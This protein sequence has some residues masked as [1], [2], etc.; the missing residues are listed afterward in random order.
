MNTT[1]TAPRKNR[2]SL[3]VSYSLLT[4]TGF[5]SSQSAFSQA[6]AASGSTLDEIIVTA[7]RRS[8][9]LQDVPVAVQALGEKQLKDLRVANLQ[10][11]VS[12][13]PGVN[14]T[15]Q[16]PGRKEV[17]I[18]GISP[19]RTAERIAALGSEASVASY[20]DETPTSYA[21]RD[22]DLYAADFNR[23][24]VLKGPQGTLFGASSQG[25]AIRLITNKPDPEEFAA[26]IAVDFADTSGGEASN[27]FEG[28]INIP[29][30]AD[31][32]ALRIVAYQDDRGGY[33]DNIAATR[34][35]PLTNPGLQ[36]AATAGVVGF[37]ET[38]NNAAL[39]EDDVNDAEYQG[40]RASLK[41]FI[42]D[43]WS[44]TATVISQT[45]DT[46]GIFEF[47]PDVS[48]DDDLNAR[49][50]N[51][52]VGED[53][54]DLIS[55]N[56]EGSVGDLD[57]IYSGSYTER[58]FEG[59]TDY[60]GYANTGPFIP[61][62]IC[63]PGYTSCGSPSLITDSFFETERTTHE[64]RIASNYDSPFNFIAGIFLDDQE[65]IERTNFIY[66]ASVGVGFQPNFPIPTAFAS[67]PNAR[68]PGVTFFN[69]FLQTTEELS[70]FGEVSY[71]FNDRFKLTLGARRYDIDI[72]LTGQSSFG[73]RGSGPEAA[74]GVNVDA[75]LAG[76]T[77]ASLSDTIFRFN[78]SYDV[79]DNGLLYFT[80]SEGFRSGRF[81]RNGGGGNGPTPIPFFFESDNAK[82]YE[83]GYKA[84]LL[85]NSLRFSAAAYFVDFTDLQQGVL[86]FSIDNV[87]FFD[88]VG[89]A[90]IRGFEFETDWAPTDNLRLFSSFSYID[91]ELVELPETVANIAPEGSELPF[92]PK[93]QSTLGARYEQEFGNLTGF[94]QGVATYTDE[95]FTSLVQAAR[96]QLD[97]Y[98]QVNTSIGVS[99]DNWTAS[100]YVDNLTDELGT[101]DG[102][103]PD[104]IFRLIPIRPRT[105]G[106]RFNYNF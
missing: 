48:G 46:E 86:D 74:G 102:G 30:V 84:T 38:A 14:A 23:I 65:T 49:V 40:Y 22:I 5:S 21:G 45:L 28:F 15:G 64:I 7:T 34:Q 17:F 85:D 36:A 2:L 97:S 105:I 11:Y 52:N 79:N 94:A 56:I 89:D 98:T 31:T 42:N 91:S 10:D 106:V 76:Q 47:E 81:N 51:Q 19:G 77:P 104:L 50:F 99:T 62:Y 75:N 33:I 87:S 88:N 63:T 4:L 18:R 53:E 24:E 26:G 32:T 100:L 70:L 41:H 57:L 90:E 95:R 1:F 12:L 3:A 69:D 73:S 78:A 101:L 82:N 83:L 103:A 25:G 96:F 54:V 29:I 43:N 37:R 68:E 61:Y 60:T 80:F 44:A 39:V 8:E 59:Q 6:T 20:L 66:P 72:G 16:G 93:L 71:Q 58:L 35:I 13:L 92:A 55:L 9:S 67:N 27:T